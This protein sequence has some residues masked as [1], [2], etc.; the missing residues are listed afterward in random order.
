MSVISKIDTISALTEQATKYLKAIRHSHKQ[1]H[2]DL[3]D[4]ITLFNSVQDLQKQCVS[5]A[6]ERIKIWSDIDK[7]LK[8]YSKEIHEPIET[9]ETNK[10][11]FKLSASIFI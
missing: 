11:L 7:K 10:P 2:T 8:T 4:S 5:Q 6:G 9:K 3:P 1:P